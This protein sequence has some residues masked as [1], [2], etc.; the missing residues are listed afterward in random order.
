MMSSTKTIKK[1]FKEIV[2]NY[3]LKDEEIKSIKKQLKINPYL[4]DDYGKFYSLLL[5]LGISK[6]KAKYV[7][8]YI[9]SE[10]K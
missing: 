2:N 9:F 6:N 7:C 10:E 8:D 4:F 5:S 1:R 3:S